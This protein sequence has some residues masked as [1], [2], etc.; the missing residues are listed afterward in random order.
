MTKAMPMD[1]RFPGGVES[2]IFLDS[3]NIYCFDNLKKE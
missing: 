1:A 3:F 2:D